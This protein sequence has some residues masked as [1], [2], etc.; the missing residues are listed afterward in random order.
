MTEHFE[1]IKECQRNCDYLRLDEENA[2]N[3]YYHESSVGVC[4]PRNCPKWG[5]RD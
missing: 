5:G 2:P 4:N 3:C 1:W